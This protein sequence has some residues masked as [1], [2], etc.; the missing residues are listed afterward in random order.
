MRLASVATLF[1]TPDGPVTPDGRMALA[2]HLRELRAR[3][4]RSVVVL[5]AAMVVALFFYDQTFNLIY[6]PYGDARRQLGADVQTEAYI[7]GVAGPLLLQLKLSG[8]T[9]LVCTGCCSS[10]A[11][12]S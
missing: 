8:I 5:V 10:S 12:P 9:A 4:L 1:R 6:A 2:D 3:L 11:W 7:K